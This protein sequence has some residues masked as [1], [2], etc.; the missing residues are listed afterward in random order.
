MD[1][2]RKSVPGLLNWADTVIV[3]R[4]SPGATA[5]S[6]KLLIG[7]LTLSTPVVIWVESLSVAACTLTNWSRGLLGSLTVTSIASSHWYSTVRSTTIVAHC[8]PA[9]SPACPKRWHAGVWGGANWLSSSG[10]TSSHSRTGS[11]TASP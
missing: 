11:S 4:K 9:A 8:W 6:W 10:C 2:V 1:G 5:G 7:T 3:P